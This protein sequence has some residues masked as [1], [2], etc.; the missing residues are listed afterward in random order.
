MNSRETGGQLLDGSR[1]FY[2]IFHSVSVR[3]PAYRN[4]NGGVRSA[5]VAEANISREFKVDSNVLEWCPHLMSDKT[6]EKNN[7]FVPS[8]PI[9]GNQYCRLT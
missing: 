5:A 4:I 1:I 8:R 6:K 9:S 3:A 7:T 2:R